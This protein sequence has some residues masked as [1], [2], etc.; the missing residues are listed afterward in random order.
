M[1]M[2]EWLA[3]VLGVLGALLVAANVSISR[4]GFVLFL[5]S[6]LLWTYIAYNQDLAPLLLNQV[7]FVAINVLG[8]QRWFAPNESSIVSANARS[9]IKRR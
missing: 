9:M 2:I 7:V 4:Y 1:E 5:V 8:I 3:A 6:S